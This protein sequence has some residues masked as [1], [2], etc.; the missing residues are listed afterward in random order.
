MFCV[1]LKKTVLKFSEDLEKKYSGNALK[2]NL[3]ITDLE[4]K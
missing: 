2:L 1:V 3:Q 4:R